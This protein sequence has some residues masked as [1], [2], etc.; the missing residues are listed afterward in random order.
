M[1]DD[2]N[3]EPARDYHTPPPYSPPPGGLYGTP[4]GYDGPPEAKVPLAEAIQQLPRQYIK[5]L[6]KPSAATFAEEMGKASWSIFWVQL[7]GITILSSAL[8]LVELPLLP[9]YLQHSM[10]NSLNGP[11]PVNPATVQMIQGLTRNFI[12]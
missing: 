7:L 8:V 5:V 11:S 10:Q 4:P 9:A 2:H 3:Q 1:F 6:T 12:L